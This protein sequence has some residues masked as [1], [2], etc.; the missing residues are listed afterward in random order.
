MVLR[1]RTDCLSE[2]SKKL[3]EAFRK[4]ARRKRKKKCLRNRLFP[5]IPDLNM[6]GVH[7]RT[8]ASIYRI[9]GGIYPAVTR[10]LK[11]PDRFPLMTGVF[12]M[13]AEMFP[14]G[15]PVKFTGKRIPDIG[16][17]TRLSYSSARRDRQCSGRQVEKTVLPVQ[18][19][20]PEPKRHP[21]RWK[22]GMS[23]MMPA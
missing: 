23:F 18:L 7:H 4:T 22:A 20:R 16:N 19:L 21:N 15:T 13:V 1:G 17:R 8:A 3:A 11:L 12:L 5:K 9:T 6:A 2:V 14:A 10:M